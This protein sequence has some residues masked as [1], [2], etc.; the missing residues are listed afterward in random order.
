MNLIKFDN[1]IDVIFIMLGF[2]C[3]FNC[4]YCLQ[5]EFKTTE[6]CTS[7][8]KDI[9]VFIKEQANKNEHITI[10]FFGGEPLLYFNVIKDIIKDLDGVSNITYNMITNGMLLNDETI[11]FIN[12]YNISVCISWDGCNTKMSRGI[13]IFETNKKNIFKLKNGFSISSVLNAYNSPK[14]LLKD[15]DGLNDEYRVVYN[16]DLLFNIDN[17]YMLDNSNSDV[18][19]LDFK[20]YRE[21]IEYLTT[22]FIYDNSN[23]TY[24]EFNYISGIIEHIK[25]YN[26]ND[27]M[28]YSPCMNGIKVLNIDLNGNLYLCH[29]NSN[30]NLGNIYSN[31]EDY[32]NK[33]REYNLLPSY[34]NT[35]CK[36]CSIECCCSKG[37]ML[38]SEVELKDFYC[39]Q[40]R[41]LLEP[42]LE[43][44]LEYSKSV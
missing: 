39:K 26:E 21:D 28:V 44:L 3:N 24:A 11:S 22:K 41:M 31:I 32:I 37:C 14:T 33:Y 23:I 7:Y 35:Y 4:N 19:L 8:N 25:Q 15:L 12:E 30:K 2:A 6:I 17:L 10:N 16:D 18:F 40:K 43:I 38:L 29:N 5:H 42:V 36:G 34:F 1:N 27:V 20:K 13:D 9:I